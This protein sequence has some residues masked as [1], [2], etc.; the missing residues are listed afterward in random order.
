MGEGTTIFSG[1]GQISPS[2][3]A[4]EDSQNRWEAEEGGGISG[5]QGQL[6]D[7]VG[8]SRFRDRLMLTQKK[9]STQWNGL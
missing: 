3:G 1:R 2:G 4:N 8:V 5:V 7:A 9:R 6:D